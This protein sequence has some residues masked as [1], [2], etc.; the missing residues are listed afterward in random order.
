MCFVL[1]GTADRKRIIEVLR[2]KGNFQYYN[3]SKNCSE[4]FIACRRP[5]KNS[6]KDIKS[7]VC[8]PNC[9]GFFKKKTMYKHNRKCDP[10]YVK[11][12]RTIMVAGRRLL[13]QVSQTACPVLRDE[14]FPPLRDDEISN[15]VRHDELLIKFGN[16]LCQKYRSK[17]L[18]YHIRQQLRALGRLLLEARKVDSG[19]SDFASLY[20]ANKYDSV[21]QAVNQVAG[22]DEKTNVYKAPT[23]ASSLGTSVRKVGKLHIMECIK[24]DSYSLKLDAENFLKVMDVDYGASVNKTVLDNRQQH[25]RKCDDVT[26]PFKKDIKLLVDF[27]NI[28]ARK[29]YAKLENKFSFEHWMSLA[30][31]T[32][33]SIQIFNRRRAGETERILVEDFVTYRTIEQS[34]DTDTYE[35]LSPQERAAA[36]KYVRFVI[37]GKLGRTVAILLDRTTLRYVQ[38]IL[39]Y[40]SE[41]NVPVD[42]PYLFG[43][44][45]TTSWKHLRACDLLRQFSEACNAE[46]PTTLRGTSLRKHFAT[47]MQAFNLTDADVTQVSNFMGHSV[48]I[49]K[50]HY[51]LSSA[52]VDMG[53]I[54]NLLEVVQS[55]SIDKSKGGTLQDVCSQAETSNEINTDLV[56]ECR[57]DPPNDAGSGSGVSNDDENV[58]ENRLLTSTSHHED[59]EENKSNDENPVLDH[60]NV[61]DDIIENRSNEFS[62]DADATLVELASKNIDSNSDPNKSNNLGSVESSR[63][64]YESVVEL[65]EVLE[66]RPAVRRRLRLENEINRQASTGTLYF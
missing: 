8:C 20:A 10:N 60:N 32:L 2:K 24:S 31:Y 65:T 37:R 52:A 28:N 62:P 59:V 22:L 13:S 45:G 51:L 39:K 56:D 46:Q 47:V 44:P 6:C 25:K 54:S 18:H 64:E 42:N 4:D 26:L 11:G 16:Q 3:N 50:N 15:V 17:H 58:N 5:R 21:K 9:Q 63:S 23:L 40:R 12:R 34:A 19:I 29:A 53:R 38:T 36:Q 49:H 7:Y 14:V 61:D 57:S 41:A 66:E 35:I 33:I 43:V 55:G 27:L 30:Q 48:N 1:L